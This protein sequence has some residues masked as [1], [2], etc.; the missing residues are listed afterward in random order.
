MQHRTH[1]NRSGNRSGNRSL[2]TGLGAGLV[3]ILVLGL[4][5]AYPLALISSRETVSI[6]VEDKE[7]G[8]GSGDTKTA[9]LVFAKGET[10]EVG[11]SLLALHFSSADVY[12]KLKRGETY[13]CETQG[14]RVPLLSSYKN[15]IKC[16]F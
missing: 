12:R 13:E 5:L 7:R 14:F 1:K 16:D 3:A 6:T 10:Y 9:T 4:V 8:S 15:I 11:D 2:F